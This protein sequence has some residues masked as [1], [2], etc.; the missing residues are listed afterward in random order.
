MH[1]M[2]KPLTKIV[3]SNEISVEANKYAKL[4][5]ELNKLKDK[6]NREQN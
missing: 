6:M 4:N 5:I 1:L 3:F 2:H